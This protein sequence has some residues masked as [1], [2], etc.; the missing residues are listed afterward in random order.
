MIS[1]KLYKINKGVLEK[2]SDEFKDY[3]N[4][5]STY[6]PENISDVSMSSV[7]S[8]QIF[9]SM[10]KSKNIKVIKAIP[11]LPLRYLSR[12]LM[13]SQSIKKEELEE[14]NQRIQ[15]NITDKFIRTFRRVSY[16]MGDLDIVSYPYEVDEV[17]TLKIENHKGTINNDL[18]NNI[19]CDLTENL[20]HD[21]K[22]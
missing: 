20:N 10:L 5:D 6:Y 8:L 9:I 19:D 12:E 11:Y 1:R 15:M 17:M 22:Y 2:E 18:L 16:H 3:K 4:G 7:L 21:K 13:A 14:R